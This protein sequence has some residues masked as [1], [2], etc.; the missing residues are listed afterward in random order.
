MVNSNEPEI[1]DA[2]AEQEAINRM[3]W[4][5]LVSLASGDGGLCGAPD[6]L[7]DDTEAI[8]Y[9]FIRLYGVVK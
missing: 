1:D 8:L 7:I 6:R 9:Q 3:R 5:L 2:I 4:Q